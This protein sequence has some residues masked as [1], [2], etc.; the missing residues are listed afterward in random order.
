MTHTHRLLIT[1]IILLF[2]CTP[3]AYN[4]QEAIGRQQTPSETEI[5]IPTPEPSP[6]PTRFVKV[7]RVREEE[8]YAAYPV[9]DEGEVRVEPTAEVAPIGYPLPDSRDPAAVI[10]AKGDA[11]LVGRY[12]S[13]NGQWEVQIIQYD[14]VTIDGERMGYEMFKL[15][16]KSGYE[17]V[18]SAV[19]YTCGYSS[20]GYDGL[21]WSD[22][23]RYFYYTTARETHHETCEGGWSP[24]ITRYDVQEKGTTIMG[25]GKLS[26]DGTKLATW[27]WDYGEE[28]YLV[29]RDVNEGHEIGRFMPPDVGVNNTGRVMWAAN[30]T[31][32]MY[33]LVEE[34]C[35]EDGR[36][37]MINGNLSDW[38]QTIVAEMSAD[39]IS[40][41]E[42]E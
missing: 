8:E 11:E 30:G 35:G 28:A 9:R 4:E 42:G 40:W 24:S 13:P 5:P 19:T 7:N 34:V 38:T 21:F 10:V 27:M 37:Y 36:A 31:N 18:E 1:L 22:N 17:T 41:N 15:V 12:P 32:V 2:G 39:G 25:A 3:T 33:E 26:P 14:C 6:T 16:N 23:S 29:V 20:Y